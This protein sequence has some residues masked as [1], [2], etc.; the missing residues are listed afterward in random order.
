[1]NKTTFLVLVVIAIGLFSCNKTSNNNQKVDWQTFYF[2][3]DT[4]AGKYIDKLVMFVPVK[5]ENDTTVYKMQFD[6]GANMTGFYENP[7]REIASFNTKIDTF[8]VDQ[9][10]SG[11]SLYLDS[12]K[13][14]VKAFP[15][16]KNYGVKGS[17]LIG[18]IGVNDFQGKVLIIDYPNEKFA[19]L[20]SISETKE[21]QYKSVDFETVQGRVVLNLDINE[22][23]YKFMFDTGSSTT[24]LITTMA[25]YEKFTSNTKV[26]K[27]TIK[28]YSWGIKV[29]TPGAKNHYPIKVGD[30]SLKANSTVY[31]TD[32]EHT[33]AFFK[34][35]NIDG[36]ISNPFF[37]NDVVLIDFKNKKFGVKK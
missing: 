3:S 18:T 35:T 36:L 28:A 24:P 30:L 32:A 2:V 26:D 8:N 1:M 12:Y 4:V 14:Q 22:Q 21:L 6:T 19:I 31:G 7:I 11:I 25:L 34:D 16:R 10:S 13:S 37:F 15:I 9:Y 33:L 27:D 17:K 20:D 5:V 29:I 23:Q